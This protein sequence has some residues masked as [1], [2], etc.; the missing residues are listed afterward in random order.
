MGLTQIARP[1]FLHRQHELERQDRDGAAVQ[2]HTLEQL[3]KRA[4]DTEYGKAH[5]FTG[6][7]HY[8]DFAGAVPVNTYEELKADIDR[9]RHG[10]SDILWPGR[11]RWFAKSSGTTAD[12]SKFIPVSTEG[13]QKAHYSGGF[14]AVA[15][16]LRNNPDSRIFDGKSLILGGSHDPNYDVKDSMVGDVSAIMLR[17]NGFPED[18]ALPCPQVPG[19]LPADRRAGGH[20]RDVRSDR[21]LRAG[22]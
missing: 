1:V 20:R 13:L 9:M 16:Y 6:I 22:R 7:R 8:E 19:T 12:K 4:C 2:R 14:D 21:G 18:R 17:E 5:G 10:E 11:V 3:L 15:Y